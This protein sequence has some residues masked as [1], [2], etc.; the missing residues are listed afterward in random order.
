M[1][2]EKIIYFLKIYDISPPFLE[3]QSIPKLIYVN[4]IFGI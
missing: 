2:K 4:E 3:I 1:L